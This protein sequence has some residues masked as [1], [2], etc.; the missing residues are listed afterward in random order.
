MDEYV[1]AGDGAQL[2]IMHIQVD[3][4]RFSPSVYKQILRDWRAFRACTDAPLVGIE[5]TPDD[6]KWE[7]FVSRLGFKY[8]NQ[9][10]PLTDGSSLRVFV[11]VKDD[12]QN[13]GPQNRN[14]KIH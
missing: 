13:N 7:R 10:I 5:D 2:L 8:S 9:R 1:R 4:L 11:S 12:I 6:M 3:S 14:P